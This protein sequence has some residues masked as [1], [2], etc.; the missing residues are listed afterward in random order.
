MENL[1]LFPDFQDY[2]GT[3]SGSGVQGDRRFMLLAMLKRFPGNRCSQQRI[4]LAHALF[5]L[6]MVSTYE[7]REYL[8]IY[9]PTA[10][11]HDLTKVGI[12]IGTGWSTM[13][14]A[15]G[16]IRS[17]GTYVLLHPRGTATGLAQLAG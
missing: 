3:Q 9:S 7:C 12:L 11:K 5:A 8:D 6:R 15:D 14:T 17:I 4:R 2:G 16:G 13:R 10:R 1:E